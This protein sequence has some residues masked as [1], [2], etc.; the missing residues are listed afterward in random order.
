[1]ISPTSPDVSKPLCRRKIVPLARSTTESAD[2]SST[3]ASEYRLNLRRIHTDTVSSALIQF[4]KETLAPNSLEWLFL[5]DSGAVTS[6][7]S[8]VTIDQIFKGPI[9]RHKSS[10]KKLM[11]DSA[12]PAP[13]TRWRKWKFDREI[14]SY[15]VSGKMGTLREVAFSLDYKD[16][17]FLL[18]RLPQIPHVRTLYILRISDSHLHHH[19][20]SDHLDPKE[21]ALQLMDVVAFRP[22]V[23]LCYL[24]ISNKCFEIMEGTSSGDDA[25]INFRDGAAVS[26]NADNSEDDVDSDDDDED[27][28]DD[29][30]DDDGGGAMDLHPTANASDGNGDDEWMS[31]TDADSDILMGEDGTRQPRLKLREILFYDDKV[32]VFRARHRKL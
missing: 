16:W 19:H 1:M 20:H 31:D 15:I 2:L 18:Q 5:Q 21:L 25:G 9:R 11:I 32:D 23:E 7:S 12:G 10:L 3:P 27:D 6:E 22:D 8:P 28:E 13:S 30:D 26:A 17:H 4:L 24:G 14:L 29:D